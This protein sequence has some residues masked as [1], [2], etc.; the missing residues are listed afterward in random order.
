MLLAAARKLY[1]ALAPHAVL[2][3]GICGAMHGV[4]RFTRD[5]DFAADLLPEDLIDLL[6]E[7]GITAQIRRGTSVTEPLSWVI[8]GD[9]DGVP[10]QIL[11]AIEISVDVAN[12]VLK[13]DLGFA[14]V[15]DFITSKCLAGGHQ[16]L[17]D[18]A[19]LILQQPKLNDFAIS[20][21]NRFNC[22]DKLEAWLNDQ[23]LISRYS[24]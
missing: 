10:F 16:D 19:A 12:A 3:G 14:S 1:Q 21:A 24:P 20:Q 6:S 9:C 4:E 2:I 5:I 23:R 11:P 7:K 13:V 17:H 8:S 15:E 18:V 22:A